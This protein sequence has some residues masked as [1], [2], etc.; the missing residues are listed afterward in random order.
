MMLM[1]QGKLEFPKLTTTRVPYV[2]KF[3]GYQAAHALCGYLTVFFVSFW[4]I[5]CNVCSAT[6]LVV[7]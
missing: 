1:R 5:L 4:V 2:S 3:L 6:A 7:C